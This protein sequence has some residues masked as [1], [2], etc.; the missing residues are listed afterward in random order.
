M[1]INRIE[2]RVS[3]SQADAQQLAQKSFATITALYEKTP[4]NVEVRALI[5]Q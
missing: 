5:G 4:K 3:R 2:P 1:H